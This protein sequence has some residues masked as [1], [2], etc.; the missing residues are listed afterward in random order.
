MK[1]TALLLPVLA[2]LACSQQTPRTSATPSARPS[3]PASATP[4]PR[5]PEP[6]LVVL[7]SSDRTVAGNVQ[8]SQSFGYVSLANPGRVVDLGFKGTFVGG[9]TG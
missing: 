7:E 2:L 9:F 6:L 3:A 5:V 4:N 8:P 1:R